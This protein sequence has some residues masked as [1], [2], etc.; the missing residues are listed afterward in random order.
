MQRAA[1]RLLRMLEAMALGCDAGLI[2]LGRQ[3][4]KST[5]GVLDRVVERQLPP[6]S[7]RAAAPSDE[8]FVLVVA[9]DQ[10]RAAHS[11]H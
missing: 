3:R 2:A 1:A 10:E 9:T 11:L 7:G 4:G 8:R 6:G 5:A